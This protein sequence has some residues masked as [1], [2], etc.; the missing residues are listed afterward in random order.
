M[1]LVEAPDIFQLSLYCEDIPFTP[2]WPTGEQ[3]NMSL[4]TYIGAYPPIVMVH[5]LK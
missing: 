1:G 4:K 2:Q 5:S 3:S